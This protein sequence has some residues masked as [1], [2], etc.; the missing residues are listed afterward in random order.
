MNREQ[1]NELELKQLKAYEQASSLGLPEALREIYYLEMV[2]YSLFTSRQEVEFEGF[3]LRA[4]S[5]PGWQ[6]SYTLY[7][8]WHN[9]EV[10]YKEIVEHDAIVLEIFR[11]GNWIEKVK[12]YLRQAKAAKDEADK[13]FKETCSNFKDY[14]L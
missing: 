1:L 4:E 8:L 9:K 3:K 6:F 13:Q 7:T 14:N 5:V 2:K 10:L 12:N 11:S